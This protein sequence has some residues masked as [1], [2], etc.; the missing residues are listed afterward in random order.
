[1][2]AMQETRDASNL[3]RRRWG[4]LALEEKVALG[5]VAKWLEKTN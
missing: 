4:T 5:Q 2:N 3:G 1:M